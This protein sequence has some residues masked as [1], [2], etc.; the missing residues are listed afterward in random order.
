MTVIMTVTV[1]V[2]VT[3]TMT[4]TVTMTVSTG[5]SDH[6]HDIYRDVMIIQNQTYQNHVPFAWSAIRSHS[7]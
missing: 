2:T 3:V 1:T 5:H 4:M 6:A 7:I